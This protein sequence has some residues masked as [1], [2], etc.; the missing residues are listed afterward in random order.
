MTKQVQQT[1]TEIALKANLVSKEHIETLTEF[2]AKVD[3]AKMEGILGDDESIWVETSPAICKYMNRNGLGKSGYFDYQ[4]VKVCEMG[5][6]EEIKENLSRQLGEIV[7][8]D[9]TVNQITKTRHVA[10]SAQT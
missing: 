1:Q 8:G 2:Q 7:H 9:A 6:S 10:G 4:G 3:A 5:K